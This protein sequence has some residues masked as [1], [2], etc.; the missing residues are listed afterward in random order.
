MTTG[1]LLQAVKQHLEGLG[2]F[3]AVVFSELID[4]DLCD[5]PKDTHMPAAAIKDGDEQ[6]T[7]DRALGARTRRLEVL[8]GVYGLAQTKPGQGLLAVLDLAEALRLALHRNYLGRAE[9]RSAK[10]VEG[11]ASG[12]MQEPARLLV[13]KVLTFRYELEEP[14]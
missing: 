1:E 4:R 3:K 9:I 14:S 6:E 13:Q 10:Y 11:Q 7:E 8:V 2:L 12:L 5:L